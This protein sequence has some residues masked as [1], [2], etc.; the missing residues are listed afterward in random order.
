MSVEQPPVPDDAGTTVELRS[1]G[2]RRGR[3]LLWGGLLLAGVLG[4]ALIGVLERSHGSSTPAVAGI[5][6]APPVETWAAGEKL[7]PDFALHDEAGQ[8]VSLAAFRGRPVLLAFM[9]PQCGDFCPLEAKIIDTALARLPASERPTVI[10]LS[11]NL[12]GNAPSIL[13]R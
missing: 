1:G 8:P 7:A 10:A 6:P 12:W 13:R 9:D 4:G 11:V 2:P 3:W 5:A